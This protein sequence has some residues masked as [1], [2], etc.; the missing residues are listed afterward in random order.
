MTW[1]L[2]ASVACQIAFKHVWMLKAG[3]QT[4]NFLVACS[5]GSGASMNKILAEVYL[6]KKKFANNRLRA[7]TFRGDCTIV[8]VALINR[9]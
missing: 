9:G 3:T 2:G 8:C 6:Y 7:I 1:F 5:L 4:I